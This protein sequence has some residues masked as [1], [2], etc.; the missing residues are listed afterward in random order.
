[1]SSDP[2]L[3]HPCFPADRHPKAAAQ[4]IHKYFGVLCNVT[5]NLVNHS[6]PGR[7]F[8]STTQKK[9]VTSTMVMSFLISP[10]KIHPFPDE[11][12]SSD[13]SESICIGYH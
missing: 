7:R 4:S 10:M 5:S 12:M 13:H 8:L 3:M 1:M 6:T 9:G 11:A 2:E